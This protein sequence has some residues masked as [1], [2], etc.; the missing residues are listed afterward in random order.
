M[1]IAPKGS[2]LAKFI[3]CRVNVVINDHR[4]FIGQ[5][6][7]FDTHSNII[8]KDCE[9]FRKLKKRKSG[10]AL[11]TKR[12]IG[13]MILRGDTVLHVDVI[14]PPPPNGNRLAA[15]SASAV[16]QPGSV[17]EKVIGKGAGIS[18]EEKPVNFTALTKPTSGIGT[19]SINLNKNLPPPIPSSQLPK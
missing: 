15:S 18:V 17:S 3:N 6:L 19:S 2:K 10:E 13:L 11:E 8:L 5:M 7:G 12:N 16:L 9:E 1:S 14:G 4:Y